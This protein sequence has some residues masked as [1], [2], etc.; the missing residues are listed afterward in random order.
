MP[1]AHQLFTWNWPRSPQDSLACEAAASNRLRPDGHGQAHR[2]A[3]AK[4]DIT[5][6]LARTAGR[7]R[8]ALRIAAN[9][10]ALFVHYVE[11][12]LSGLNG[13][14]KDHLSGW[15]INWDM[16][17]AELHHGPRRKL[18]LWVVRAGG[19]RLEHSPAQVPSAVGETRP[20]HPAMNV[21]V[22][23]LQPPHLGRWS[24]HY[25]WNDAAISQCGG[26]QCPPPVEM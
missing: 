22:S 3:V 1:A 10:G 15:N 26:A 13:T 20:R 24:M 4:T 21:A 8:T 7:T 12:N 17:G 19:H 6:G 18:H 14:S 11:S 5:T 9:Q 16:A 25:V 23:Q 2:I